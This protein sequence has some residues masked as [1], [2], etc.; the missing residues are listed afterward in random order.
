MSL[1]FLQFLKK[2]YPNDF[3]KIVR[4]YKESLYPE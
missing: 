2:Y 1:L 3:D 4:H